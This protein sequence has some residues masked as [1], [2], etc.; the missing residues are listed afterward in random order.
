MTTK[1]DLTSTRKLVFNKKNSLETCTVFVQ[2]HLGTSENDYSTYLWPSAVVLAQFINFNR[3]LFENKH[4]LE[5][6]AGTALPSLLVG[7]CTKFSSLVVTD[8]NQEPR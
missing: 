2:T 8:K 6:G 4:V 5:I 1:T 3:D 7:K